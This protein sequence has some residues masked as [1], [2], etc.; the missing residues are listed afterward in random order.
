MKDQIIQPVNDA[1]SKFEKITP[2]R[3][4]SLVK[5]DYINRKIGGKQVKPI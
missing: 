3:L 4:N 2:T 5:L 1:M